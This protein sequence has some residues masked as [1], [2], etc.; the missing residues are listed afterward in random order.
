MGTTGLHA[1]A[2]A[3]GRRA[4]QGAPGVSVDRATAH[5]DGDA[6]Q[7]AW[8]ECAGG[9]RLLQGDLADEEA[10]AADLHVV[11]PAVIGAARAQGAVA[12]E[13][14]RED[15]C[16]DGGGEE[17]S[18]GAKNIRAQNAALPL[19]SV[20]R[21]D[22][23]GGGGGGL[24]VCGQHVVQGP[25]PYHGLAE[26]GE[27]R[28]HDAHLLALVHG[29][30]VEG[31]DQVGG[32]VAQRATH[33]GHA[34][35]AHAAHRV[36]HG[37]GQRVRQ[38]AGGLQGGGGGEGE[39]V[40]LL[41]CLRECGHVVQRVDV[42]SQAAKQW[43]RHQRRGARVHGGHGQAQL[44]VGDHVAAACAAGWERIRNRG[45]DGGN[46]VRVVGRVDLL[47]GAGHEKGGVGL[48][49]DAKDGA[50]GREAHAAVPRDGAQR[51][52]GIRL[53]AARRCERVVDQQLRGHV[54]RQVASEVGGR[55]RGP[56]SGH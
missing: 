8:E 23:G 10:G 53:C 42:A 32:A 19:G 35:P 1:A 14:C 45:H 13:A 46:G 21:G 5:G 43:G 4:V 50:T 49:A 7:Q 39:K 12:Q 37:G 48:A 28:V 2:A 51:R 20:A 52:A 17:G 55:A 18:S 36:E 31:A 40:P 29:R 34:L 6:V 22:V 26:D 33:R 44:P 15:T 27:Q 56:H 25:A 41:L 54:A 3:R 30:E 9:G 47:H 38:D 24:Q 16:G 11:L